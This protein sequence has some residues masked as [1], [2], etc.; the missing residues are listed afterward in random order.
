MPRV[1]TIPLHSTTLQ[2]VVTDTQAKALFK[3]AE[4]ARKSVSAYVRGVMIEHFWRCSQRTRLCMRTC[5]R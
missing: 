5:R 1:S 3:A 4:R 2:F